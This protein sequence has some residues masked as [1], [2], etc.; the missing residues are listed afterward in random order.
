MPSHRP[1]ANDPTAPPSVTEV[2]SLLPKEGLK[3]A[4]AKETAEFAYH[5]QN[6]W[7]ALNERTA[8]EL[9]RKHFDGVWKHR[10][11]LGTAL[12]ELNAI[13]AAG[14]D[15][16]IPDILDRMRSESP[17]WGR[18]QLEEIYAEFAPMV[19]GLR[20]AWKA[21]KPKT[22]AFEEVVRFQAWDSSLNY[23]GSSDW[24]A[25]VK[26]VATLIDLKTTGKVTP[27]TAKY[28]DAWRLQTAAYRYANQVV[29]YDDNDK[30]IGVGIPQPVELVKILHVRSNGV[31]EIDTIAAD[32]PEHEAFMRLR[33]AYQWLKT[34]GTWKGHVDD[35]T[36]W[37]LELPLNK[38][39]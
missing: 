2:L 13:W 19:D 25:E 33:Q 4:A 22:L 31:W 20:D 3:W 15:A 21:L 37:K 9:M 29:W 24:R 27:R 38:K 39:D 34:E 35:L 10:A 14:N 18:M 26:G 23:I 6:K 5:H 17:L 32:K 7:R 11:L 36:E 1:Y 8:V 16:R 28:W 12:H 30:E